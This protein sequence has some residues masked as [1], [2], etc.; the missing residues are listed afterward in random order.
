VALGR[1]NTVEVCSR[2]KRP[3]LS[4]I[5]SWRSQPSCMAG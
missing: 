3:R 5:S 4:P 1:P 2:V